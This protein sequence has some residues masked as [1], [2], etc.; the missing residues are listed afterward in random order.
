MLV[1]W[2]GKDVEIELENVVLDHDYWMDA[3]VSSGYWLD[4]GQ[5]LTDSELEEISSYD[6]CD[7]MYK[8][9]TD[10]LY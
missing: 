9:I 3:Y 7:N 4:T 1:K 5:N 10:W 6:N 2:R 8:W